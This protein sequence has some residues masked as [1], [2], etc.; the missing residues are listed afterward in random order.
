LF[1]K[2]NTVI[3]PKDH[4]NR[5]SVIRF[6]LPIPDSRFPILLLMLAAC[7]V[8]LTACS[9]G[10]EPTPT[11]IPPT[12]T[13]IPTN[14]PDPPTPTTGPTNT[15]TFVAVPTSERGF[16]PILCYHHIREWEKTD[17][18][19]DRAYIVPPSQLE[20]HLRYLKDNSYHAV[21]S[22]DIYQ[23]Y[24]N[25]KPL[26]EKPIMLSFDDDDDNQFTNAYPLLKKYGF[27]ATFFIMTV[28]MDKE[29]YMTSDQIKELDRAG[30]DI[31]P[32]TWDHHMVTDYKTDDDWQLQIVGPRKTLE[33]LLGHPA[34]YFAYPFGVYSKETAEKIKSYGYKAAFRLRE[35]MDDTADPLFAIKRNIANSYW[36]I[37]QFAEALAGLY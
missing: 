8:L 10:A 15:P 9:L 33:G 16:V 24:A 26:P 13:T 12:A 18:E 17:S 35:V 5:E 3:M 28:T 1:E 20:E 25:G 7:C 31:Q 4:R 37:D 29:N 2:G 19:E 36:T 23:Y 11:P 21:V 6:R 30:F 27:K 34:P 22:E 32:H 14:T